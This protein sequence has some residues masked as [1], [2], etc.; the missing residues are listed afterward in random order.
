[1]AVMT[2]CP[3]AHCTV[4]VNVDPAQVCSL[5]SH[6]SPHESVVVADGGC[7]TRLLGTDWYVLEYTNCYANMVGFDE[8]VA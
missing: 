1:M 8:F 7:D 4:C 5:A 6:L 3:P 2:P